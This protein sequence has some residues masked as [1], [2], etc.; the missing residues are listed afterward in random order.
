MVCCGK[1]SLQRKFYTL[2]GV[3]DELVQVHLHNDS[4]DYPDYHSCVL[5]RWRSGIEEHHGIVT[6]VVRGWHTADC[7]LEKVV[8][9]VRVFS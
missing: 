6:D 1:Q 7:A 5:E 8:H 3:A 9:V 2:P 4:L